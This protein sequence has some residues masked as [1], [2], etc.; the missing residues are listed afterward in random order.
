MLKRISS[1][2]F[3]DKYIEFH[4]GLNV[5]LG[6]NK[7]SNSIGKSTLL[8][9][10]DYVYGGETYVSHNEDVKKNLGDHTFNII[11]EFKG[12][13]HFYIR[14]TENKGIA[15]KCNH[16]FKN[17]KQITVGEY[18]KELKDLYEMDS[19]QISFRSA[20]DTFLRIWGKD[21]Y[22]VKLPL[23]S[24]PKET[25]NKAVIKLVKIFNK[26]NLIENHDKEIKGL[27]QEK[28][29]LS[30]AGKLN[31]IPKITKTEFNKNIKAINEIT[32]EIERIGKNIYSPQGD[33]SEL[34]S[35]EM[36]DLR[37]QKKNLIEEKEYYVSRLFRTNKKVK[38]VTPSEF[39]PL[40][41]FFEDVNIEK[42]K[43]IQSFHKGISEILTDE[44]EI[45][46][47]NLANKIKELDIEL[48]AI[49]NKQDELIKP[50]EEI[51]IFIDSLIDLSSNLKNLQ[52]ENEYYNKS[53]DLTTDIKSKKKE[54]EDVKKQILEEIEISINTDLNTLNGHIY[55][56][57]RKAPKLKL[58]YSKYIYDFFDNKG[59]GKAY[60]NL[61][62]LDLAILSLTTLPIV[63]H[64]SFLF[65]NIEKEA[66]ENLVEIYNSSTKQIF[67]SI[68]MIHIYKPETRKILKK[69]KVIELSNKKLLTPL[70]WRQ[71]TKIAEQVD[72]EKE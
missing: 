41:E 33:I 17:P 10:I 8:M 40:L 62:I 19:K 38:H 21:N 35:Q 5:V 60:S 2:I 1:E 48:A 54:F 67:I 7:A 13:K 58:T 64:D 59:T 15:F 37:I 45:A 24:Y 57:Q 56:S 28:D 61:I 51:S 66:V 23:H 26:Y 27:E 63:I 65:K 4:E 46:R 29:V 44:L 49:I 25:Y 53:I 34:L 3:A 14:T 36:M 69:K 16:N 20:I 71:D 30:R 42:I 72:I 70:D 39:E 52:L 31:L 55:D 11:F 22:N 12:V 32:T 6:D 18:T 43:S 47:E 50:D 68:D 9:I